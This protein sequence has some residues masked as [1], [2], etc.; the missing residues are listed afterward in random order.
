MSSRERMSRNAL[1]PDGLAVADQLTVLVVEDDVFLRM[2]VAETL[3]HASVTVLEADSADRAEKVLQEHPEI[4]LM[5]TDVQM[6]G[7]MDG[8]SLAQSVLTQRPEIKV[9]VMSGYW[10]PDAGS[11]PVH[12]V[13]QK[14][15]S[16]AMMLAHVRR[17]L[18]S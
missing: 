15:F 11:P 5:I 13:L 18:D 7:S 2:D 10:R 16:N 14:P 3:T 6:P 12:A 17:L 9:I 4:A 8:L 1:A